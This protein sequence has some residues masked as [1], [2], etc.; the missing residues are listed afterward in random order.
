MTQPR[1]SIL[2]PVYNAEPFLR[3][4]LDSVK[5]QTFTDFEAIC[6]NDGSTDGSLQILKEYA[7]Q[8]PRLKI[9]DKANSGYGDS[10]NQAI[11]QAKGDY[12]GIVEPDDYIEPNMFEVLYSFARQTRA[13]IVKASF[14]HYYGK[15]G[16]N[17]PENMFFRGENNQLINPK[18]TQS[19]FLVSPTIWSAI[20]RREMLLKNQ[21]EFLPTPGASYQDIGFAFKTFA[22]AETVFCSNLPLYHYRRDNSASSVNSS[23]KIMAVKNEFDGIDEFLEAHELKRQYFTIAALCRFRSYLWNYNRLRRRAALDFA[24]TA[25]QDYQK[26][27]AQG[28]KLESFNGLERAGESKLATKSPKL[29]IYLRPFYRLKN[30]LLTI[31]AKTYRK[32]IPKRGN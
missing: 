29:Y 8:D 3:E 13:D 32:I 1:L 12:I 22:C 7:S 19:V 28:F 4:C 20:Y 27:A 25:Q 6:V 30:N 24:E 5:Q 15:T 21:I 14:Y 18:K 9:I 11:K 16:K 17:Q 10:L 23:T 31:L 26:L 2:I